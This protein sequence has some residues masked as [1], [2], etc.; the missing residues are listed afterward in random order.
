M[1]HSQRAAI[2]TGS[3]ARHRRRGRRA[4]GSGRARGRRQ[5]FR[6][7]SP[8]KDLVT[9]IETA[10]GRAIAC[11]ADVSDPVSVAAM[12]EA[13]EQAFGGVDV[14]VNNA[15]IMKLAP[16]AESDDAL[17]DRHLAST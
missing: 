8:C 16:I 5:L 12:F 17:F 14:L 1:A 2:V 6:R 7:C 3:S 9:K 4:V 10:G 11:K 15:G 13:A